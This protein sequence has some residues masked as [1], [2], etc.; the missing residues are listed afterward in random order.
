[1]LCPCVM[2]KCLSCLTWIA[3]RLLTAALFPQTAVVG[4]VFTMWNGVHLSAL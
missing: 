2:A 3:A 4:E 1:M